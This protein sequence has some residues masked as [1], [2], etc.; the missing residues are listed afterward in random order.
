MT[1]GVGVSGSAG[2]FGGVGFFGGVVVFLLFF[3]RY[4]NPSFTR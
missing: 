4:L 1:V 3:L 2:R